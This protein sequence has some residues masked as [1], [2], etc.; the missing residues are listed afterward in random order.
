M[1]DLYDFMTGLF[2]SDH[3]GYCGPTCLSSTCR[4]CSKKEVLKLDLDTGTKSGSLM[5][6]EVENIDSPVDPAIPCSYRALLKV[7]IKETSPYLSNPSFCPSSPWE[8]E[9]KILYSIF[10]GLFY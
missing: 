10:F 4:V 2:V 1:I 8:V 9:K 7:N 3:A 5:D 6:V